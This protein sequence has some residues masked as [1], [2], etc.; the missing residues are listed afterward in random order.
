MLLAALVK[1]SRN[2]GQRLKP[3]RSPNASGRRAGHLL[4]SLLR[5]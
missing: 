2:G 4:A 5:K 3:V 1:A